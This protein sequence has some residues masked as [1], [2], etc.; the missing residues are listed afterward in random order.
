MIKSLKSRVIV[1]NTHEKLVGERDYY[2][3]IYVLWYTALTV[4]DV[5]S[6]RG[7]VNRDYDNVITN[8]NYNYN[9]ILIFNTRV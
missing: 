8:G 6:C 3:Y 7:S 4:A 1:D 5:Y 9:K 2:I